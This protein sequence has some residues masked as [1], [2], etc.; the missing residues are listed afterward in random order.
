M[1]YIH[2]EDVRHREGLVRQTAEEGLLTQ[3]H[4]EAPNA[5]IQL[6]ISCEQIVKISLVI[7]IEMSVMC[8]KIVVK[9]VRVLT[10]RDS[11]IVWHKHCRIV[12]AITCT[13]QT[14]HVAV[15]A[16]AVLPTMSN[17]PGHSCA[18]QTICS[19]ENDQGFRVR[20]I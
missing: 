7:Q 20:K 18:A 8:S 4:L 2:G 9:Y 12:V 11:I 1:H 17:H 3:A 6:G 10:A 13:M 16:A 14:R 15:Q 19:R 5:E